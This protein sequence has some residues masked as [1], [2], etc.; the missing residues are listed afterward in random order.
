MTAIVLTAA[1]VAAI[2]G[3]LAIL[4]GSLVLGGLLVLLTA[5]TLGHEFFAFEIGPLPLT[6][7]RVALFAL[8][9][10]YTLARRFGRTD[11]KPMQRVDWLLLTLVGYL[12]INMQVFEIL[13]PMKTEVAPMWRL[14]AGY[15]IPATIYWI[16]RQSPLDERSLRAVHW[17]MVAYCVYLAFTGLCEI[18]HQWSFVFP[19]HIA[20]PKAG[21][22]FG[23]ARGPMV[24]AVSYGT[25]LSVGMLATWISWP[26]L[27]KHGRLLILAVQPLLWAGIFYSYTRSVW[28]GAALGA[29]I[30][31][32]L[33]LQGA[34]RKIVLVGAILGGLFISATKMDSIVSLERDSSAADSKDSTALRGS[35]TY[36]SWLMFQDRPLLGVGFCHFL[37]AKLPYLS[38][39]STDMRLEGIRPLVHHNTILSLLTE[40]GII[41][42]GLFLA[43]IVSFARMGWQVYRSP[44][45]P[46][47]A[48]G[49]AVLLLGA[50]GFYSCQLMF[51]ELSYSPLDSSLIFYLAGITAGL[52]PLAAAENLPTLA[53]VSRARHELPSLE[54][55]WA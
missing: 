45:S 2:W 9:A 33:S 11:P 34:T 4:R 30:V 35:F 54:A 19:S 40:T 38:D 39:R 43:V 37:V 8:L 23:R 27:R 24:A 28:M 49:F 15:L 7:D 16:A 22:H 51:H 10:A 48:R 17:T 47:F 53:P 31:L 18:S 13:L 50:L 44:H 5:A 36:V 25:Y 46:Q 14:L 32:A 3:T 1:C 6:L 20:N 52:R 41:G 21:I 55:G 12:F 42:M 29:L 26:R